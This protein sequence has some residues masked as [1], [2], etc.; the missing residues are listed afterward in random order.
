MREGRART[1]LAVAAVAEHGAAVVACAGVLHGAA[2]A[3]ACY[4]GD[5]AGF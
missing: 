4:C 2:E 5:W 3:G 1:F